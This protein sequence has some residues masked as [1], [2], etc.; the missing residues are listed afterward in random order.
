[1]TVK[2]TFSWFDWAIK[3]IA[4]PLVSACITAVLLWGKSGVLSFVFITFFIL[5]GTVIITKIHL[6]NYSAA[7]TAIHYLRSWRAVDIFGALMLAVF[8]VAVG[9]NAAAKSLFQPKSIFGLVYFFVMYAAL[10]V[11]ARIILNK[12]VDRCS[13]EVEYATKE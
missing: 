4:M 3:R 7:W 9:C 5:L 13:T 1:M 2:N 11:S 12:F 6:K 8:E 10:A